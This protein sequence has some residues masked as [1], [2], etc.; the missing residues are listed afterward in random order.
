MF[1]IQSKNGT[2]TNI[3]V[4]VKNWLIEV[5][6]EKFICGFLVRLTANVI[7]SVRNR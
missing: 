5:L 1:V 3:D 4:D 2:M 7:K 6:V